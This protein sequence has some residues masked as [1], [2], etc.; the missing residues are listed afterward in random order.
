MERKYKA[1][2]RVHVYQ[3]DVRGARLDIIEAQ[4]YSH[5]GFDNYMYKGKLYK[6]FT[7]P[8]TGWAYILLDRPYFDQHGFPDDS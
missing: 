2:D 6:G 7:Y 1:F 8:T 4:P 3:S 5:A